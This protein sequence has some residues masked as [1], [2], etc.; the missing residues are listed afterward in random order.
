MKP[1]AITG[2]IDRRILI[3]YRA[4]RTIISKILPAPFR[5]KLVNG[6]A[7]VGICLIRLKNIRPE[8]FPLNVG[9]GSENAAHRI[10][11]EWSEGEVVREGVFIPR[12]DTSSLWNS[13]A[14][15]RLFPG[16]HHLAKFSVEERAGKYDI[17]FSSDDGTFLEV[18]ASETTRWNANSVFEDI[19][20]ASAFFER[21]A[22]GFS[23]DKTGE[24]FDG[25]QLCTTKWEI[26]P[27]DV[28]N[29]RSSF[30][31][32]TAVF[33]AASIAF[34]NALLMKEIPHRWKSLGKLMPEAQQPF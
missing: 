10:A 23:P 4:D 34:D 14:G 31:E 27:L 2:T 7:V 26:S 17:R 21:G 25:L 1:P 16:V 6:E 28:Q 5:P 12:R 19:G 18:S 15:G 24:A 3:N 8:G 11:V 33:P 9:I 22:V 30:F 29:V 32:N 13:L 20:C